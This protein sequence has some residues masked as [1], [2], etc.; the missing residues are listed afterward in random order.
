MSP[1]TSLEQPMSTPPPAE[2][3]EPEPDALD[4]I[5]AERFPEATAEARLAIKQRAQKRHEH[6]QKSIAHRQAPVVSRIETA[7]NVE[8]LDMFR[9]A[10]LLGLHR[11]TLDPSKKV[12]DRWHD[13]LWGRLCSL[14]VATQRPADACYIYN[15]SRT[16]IKSEGI[17]EMIEAVF[18]KHVAGLPSDAQWL[19]LQGIEIEGVTSLKSM[20]DK[21]KKT[22]L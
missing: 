7:A 17:A 5:I 15:Y 12:L 18:N 10:I 13:A 9:T 21:A 4:K 22:N 14:I 20:F 1:N 6:Q 8:A 16:W 19:L 3:G 11:G 2:V